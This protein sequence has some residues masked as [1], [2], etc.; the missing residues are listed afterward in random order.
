MPDREQSRK[1]GHRSQAHL[2]HE[3]CQMY[4]ISFLP[5]LPHSKKKTK[6]KQNLNPNRDLLTCYLQTS[7]GPTAGAD[8]STILE[9]IRHGSQGQGGSEQWP[10]HTMHRKIMEGKIK[11]LPPL[12]QVSRAEIFRIKSGLFSTFK[13]SICYRC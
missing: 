6:T 13:N 5:L 9:K 1:P 2:L 11:Y 3:P 12:N 8:N 7:S 4:F 10:G